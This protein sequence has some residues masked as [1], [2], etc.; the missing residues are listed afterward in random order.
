[1]FTSIQSFTKKPDITLQIKQNKKLYQTKK[2]SK[3]V[4][5]PTIYFMP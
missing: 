1:M 2:W 5:D 4:T 3:S